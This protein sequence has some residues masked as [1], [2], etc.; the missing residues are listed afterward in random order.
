MQQEDQRTMLRGDPDLFTNSALLW[1]EYVRMWILFLIKK[2]LIS[3][4]S[5]KQI[6]QD[7]K[8]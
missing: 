1:S 5:V 6:K 4:Y 3:A 7:N 2:N 8:N